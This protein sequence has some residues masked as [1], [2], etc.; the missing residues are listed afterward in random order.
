MQAT[1]NTWQ[2]IWVPMVVLAGVWCGRQRLAAGGRAADGACW[3]TCMGELGTPRGIGVA[4][5]LLQ[6]AGPAGGMRA[7]GRASSLDPPWHRAAR[8]RRRAGVLLLW[9]IAYLVSA[10]LQQPFRQRY[11][12]RQAMDARKALAN[13]ARVA[14]LNGQLAP[15]HRALPVNGGSATAV[16]A[17]GRAELSHADHGSWASA[18]SEFSSAAAPRPSPP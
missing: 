3:V 16:G 13:R 7:R 6:L 10:T 11:R 2:A 18:A 9:I 1:N 15:G 12:P 8:P 5:N 14:S 17:V 4:Q